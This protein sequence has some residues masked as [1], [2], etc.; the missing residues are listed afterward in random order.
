MKSQTSPRKLS[1]KARQVFRKQQNQFYATALKPKPR[2]V[3]W[4]VWGFLLGLVL[5]IEDKKIND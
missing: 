4:R 5:R 2:W 3:P 1:K